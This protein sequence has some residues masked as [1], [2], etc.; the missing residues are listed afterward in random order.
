MREFRGVYSRLQ[1]V[2]WQEGHHRISKSSI[3]NYSTIR[4]VKIA[5]HYSLMKVS[6]NYLHNN[7]VKLE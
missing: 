5:L 7:N 1:I 2:P 6:F 3:F 4:G